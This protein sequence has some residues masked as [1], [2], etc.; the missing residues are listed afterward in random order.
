M[1]QENHG[2]DRPSPA[3]AVPTREQANS[4]DH[5]RLMMFG[6][7]PCVRLE[8]HRLH[9]LGY[10]EATAWSQP[11]PTDRPNEVMVILTKRCSLC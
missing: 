2:S 9:I 5:V 1:F 6:P 3:I 10:A 7:L 11:M 8:I 4:G